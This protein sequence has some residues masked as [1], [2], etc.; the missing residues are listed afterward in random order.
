MVAN[1]WPNDPLPRSNFAQPGTTPTSCCPQAWPPRWGW[2]SSTSSP[3]WSSPWSSSSAWG[4]SFPPCASSPWRRLA[5]DDG[6]NIGDGGSDYG[7]VI[8]VMRFWWYDYGNGDGDACR[9][10]IC[11]LTTISIWGRLGRRGSRGLQLGFT[12][13]YLV[14]NCNYVVGVL[15]FKNN[16]FPRSYFRSGFTS[17]S[18]RDYRLAKS[19][20]FG[21]ISSWGR[22]VLSKHISIC[23][24]GQQF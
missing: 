18:T 8:L 21:R 23:V 14:A 6:D 15:F 16:F 2:P 4:L 19:S 11:E 22:Q 1:H 5:G 13:Y 24:S 3:L 20:L 9:G 17:T 7:E 10:L 12:V